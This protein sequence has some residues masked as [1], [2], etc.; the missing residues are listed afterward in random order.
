MELQEYDYESIIEQFDKIDQENLPEHHKYAWEVIENGLIND[1]R[2]SW[3]EDHLVDE[4]L[5]STQ[6]IFSYYN[7]KPY[8]P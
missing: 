8:K 3:I 4:G 5:P 6:T 2:M 7:I 1:W